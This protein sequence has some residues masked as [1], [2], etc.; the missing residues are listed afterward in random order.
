MVVLEEVNILLGACS[1]VSE[2]HVRPSVSLS[3]AYRSEVGLSTPPALCLLASTML[4]AMT[5]MD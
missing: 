1:E 2:A 3:A 4:Q 5:I